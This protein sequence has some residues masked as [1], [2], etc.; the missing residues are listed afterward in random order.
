[1]ILILHI[2]VGGWEGAEV[3]FIRCLNM[4]IEFT[5]IIRIAIYE[6]FNKLEW[7]FYLYLPDNSYCK[8]K[9]LKV[10]KEFTKYVGGY[11]DKVSFGRCTKKYKKYLSRNSVVYK[12]KKTQI[13]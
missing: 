6:L 2:L 8:Q 3:H 4:N 1:M 12:R 11:R 10:T 5:G 9:L 7:C 13:Y